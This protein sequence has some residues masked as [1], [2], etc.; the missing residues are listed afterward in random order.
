[1]ALVNMPGGYPSLSEDGE[2]DNESRKIEYPQSEASIESFYSLPSRKTS[3]ES[4]D[5]LISNQSSIENLSK[6][7][8]LQQNELT[9]LKET[10]SHEYRK[11]VGYNEDPYYSG[12][13]S[14]EQLD[15]QMR[16]KTLTDLIWTELQYD[17]ECIEIRHT[18]SLPIFAVSDTS[19][20]TAC[21]SSADNSLPYSSRPPKPP[22]INTSQTEP[23][24]HH[25]NSRDSNN[26]SVSSL[27][28]QA[29][30]IEHNV[31]K[32]ATFS[33]QILLG[34]G[35]HEMNELSGYSPLSPLGVNS[36]K[37]N[38]GT[39]PEFETTLSNNEYTFSTAYSHASQLNKFR[40]INS[41]SQTD[42][43]MELKPDD[44]QQVLSS[45]SVTKVIGSFPTNSPVDF[46]SPLEL[47]C[48]HDLHIPKRDTDS[49]ENNVKSI[50]ELTCVKD[51]NEELARR[52]LVA[53]KEN[54]V[55][56]AKISELWAKNEKLEEEKFSALSLVEKLSKESKLLNHRVIIEKQR[57][58]DMINSQAAKITMQED[59]IAVNQLRILELE[60]SIRSSEKTQI[61]SFDRHLSF[62]LKN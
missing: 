18:K 2:P 40:M 35:Q 22:V 15:R 46:C 12:S 62:Y 33:N 36:M 38:S 25:K 37:I 49:P 9:Q 44:K 14:K 52:L 51:E 50:D 17:E 53:F 47:P 23:Q 7:M 10:Q 3:I 41:E 56:T 1:M 29:N 42:L 59:L 43:A 60:N 39:M 4:N 54:D 30:L 58:M 48:N 24:I 28:S 27:A 57:D 19:L 34:V 16:R 26:M 5:H 21:I 6:I 32:Q 61:T 45:Q 20:P 31:P 55:M 13:F 11:Q 8:M